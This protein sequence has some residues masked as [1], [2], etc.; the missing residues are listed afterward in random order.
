MAWRLALVSSFPFCLIFLIYTYPFCEC[1]IGGP[2]WLPCW[3]KTPRTALPTKI[4][5]RNRLPQLKTRLAFTFWEKM[6]F[7][8]TTFLCRLILSLFLT[9]VPKLFSHMLL[10]SE[11]S[12]SCRWANGRLDLGSSPTARI[13][14]FRFVWGQNL[15]KG[16]T[17]Q[18]IF[19]WCV[20]NIS[21]EH[22]LLLLSTY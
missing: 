11:T 12:P 7:V 16:M 17:T 5:V 21:E 8:E 15:G 9:K 1:A 4:R 19:C 14:I 2:W 22:Y 10:W 3:Q 6:C 18:R 20:W 13:L